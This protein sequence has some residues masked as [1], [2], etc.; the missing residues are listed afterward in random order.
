MLRGL[1]TKWGLLRDGSA[2]RKIER[3]DFETMAQFWIDLLAQRRLPQTVRWVFAEDKA[4]LRPKMPGHQFAF[5]PRPSA[6]ADRIARFAY[7][8]LDPKK[9]LAM[10]AYAVIKDFVVVGFQGDVFTAD[11]D[12][13]RED[14]NTYFDAKE[15]LL[16]N[17]KIIF[18]EEEWKRLRAEQPHYLSEL[19]YLVS[20]DALRRRFGYRD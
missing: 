11:E 16:E 10:V 1:L 7:Q 18:D 8:A 4:R 14:W 2:A 3:P 6:E 17:C 5:R 12:V 19:D 9:P 15:N 20:V 13:Y